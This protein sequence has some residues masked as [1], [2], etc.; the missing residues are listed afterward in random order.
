MLDILEKQVK[1]LELLADGIENDAVE[2]FQNVPINTKRIQPSRNTGK[3]AWTQ[4][5]WVNPPDELKKLQD[6]LIVDYQKWFSSS[7]YL[8]K[9]YMPDR[10]REFTDLYGGSRGIVAQF[11][12]SSDK[13]SGG[14]DL[15]IY[16]WRNLFTM[17][18]GILAAI[19]LLA[20]IKERTLRKILTSDIANSEIDEAE[21]LYE[22]QH[23]RAAGAVAGVALE[24][25]LKTLCEVNGI[26]YKK[27]NSIYF[28][29]QL[30]YKHDPPVI[31]STIL[32]HMGHLASIRKDCDHANPIPDEKLKKDVRRLI[33][34][35][36]GYVQ[37]L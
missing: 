10:S 29:S 6:K 35:T 19:P 28:L 25:Y 14:R 37:K 34:D 22:N 11:H 26:E 18:R 32:N 12:L 13:L 23:Y 16:H 30:L 21:L 31:D 20:E 17:Q 27:E 36:R 15:F 3:P 5:R 1:N 24:R 7:H 8:V 33:D 9:E 4:Y 2:L